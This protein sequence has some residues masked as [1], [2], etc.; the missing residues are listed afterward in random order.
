MYQ[1]ICDFFGL[2]SHE[3]IQTICSK[4]HS[5][6]KK[7]EQQQREIE[8]LQFLATAFRHK[9]AELNTKST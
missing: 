5:L 3:E 8:E 2:Y 7:I 1:W 6:E 9:L 4:F